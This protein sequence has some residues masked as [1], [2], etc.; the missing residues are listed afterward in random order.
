MKQK[1]VSAMY[2]KT[3]MQ[4]L[5]KFYFK[6]HTDKQPIK[7]GK[8]TN[9]GLA[10]HEALEFMYRRLMQTGNVPTASDYND[11][12]AAFLDFMIKNQ[13]NLQH[14]YD[15]GRQILKRKLD[16]YSPAEKV[17]GLELRF[18]FPEEQPEINV[19]TKKGT[20]LIGAIDKIF[21]LDKD[22]IVVVDYKTSLVALT[23]DEA[24]V[25]EQLS[26]YDLVIS[27][28]YPQYKNIILVLDYL[29]LKPVITHRTEEQRRNFEFFLDSFYKKI[30][31]LKKTDIKPQINE[32]CSWCDYKEYCKEY[33]KM[34]SD[35][36]VLVKPL[37]T[38]GEGE[39]AGEWVR[40]S[41]VKR[42]VDSYKRQLDMHA[43][44]VIQKTGTTDIV[45]EDFT[46]YR[47]Q[48]SKVM[49]SPEVV[50]GIMPK[51]DF[52]SVV[53]V[54]KFGVDKYLANHPEKSGIVSENVKVS[55]G[56]PFFKYKKTK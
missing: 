17:I 12:F 36:D 26:M 29:R 55:Y 39:F 18:G 33:K 43:Q 27:Y 9:F 20:P 31:T 28:L 24:A 14:L 48:N 37:G 49:Y 5:E 6:Y 45:G 1:S 56:K 4:C 22:T 54:S 52:L 47:V 34:I 15:E 44:G 53:S 35:P 38:M 21:E 46:I 42:A 40:F 25:D 50:C 2:I 13:V 10:M 16:I 3:Y 23:D 8:I 7:Y 30:S 51:E 32:F 19:K 41:N 11:V